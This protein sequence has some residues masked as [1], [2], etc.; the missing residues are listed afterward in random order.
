MGTPD[1]N[2]RTQAI[3]AGCDGDTAKLVAS[4][5]AAALEPKEVG[6]TWHLLVPPNFTHREITDAIEKAKGTP[7][8]KRGAVKLKDIPSLLAYCKDQAYAANGYIYADP[9]TRTITAV[10][11]DQRAAD[12]PGWRDH[13]AEFTAEYTPEFSRWLRANGQQM[14]QT[15]FAEFIEDNMADIPEP[16]AQALLEVATTIQATSGISFSSAKRLQDG[17]TQLSYVE[18]IDAKAGTGGAVQI[19]KEF[20]LGLRIFKN[21][22]GYKLKARL[23]YRLSGGSVK[24]WY[25]LDRP[26]KSVEDAFAGYVSN[27]REASGYTVLIG[28]P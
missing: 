9:D 17:Q 16:F 14:D 5:G 11:N 21:G 8:R 6:D 27:V 3:V 24:F 13:R 2:T 15:A 7:N 10:F 25:E 19:P 28:T 1:N 4:L 22:D 26:E 18:N 12:T 20:A 23:K